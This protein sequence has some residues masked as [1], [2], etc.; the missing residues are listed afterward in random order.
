MIHPQQN[1][2]DVE[3]RAIAWVY[4][5]DAI[6]SSRRIFTLPCRWRSLLTVRWNFVSLNVRLAR[7]RGND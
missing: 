7:S 2:K 6:G 3:M 5:I 1:K 4:G